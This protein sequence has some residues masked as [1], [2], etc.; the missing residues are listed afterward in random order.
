MGRKVHPIGF[1]LGIIKDWQSRWYADRNYAELVQE[2]AHP[3]YGGPAPH[4]CRA[5]S[6]RDPAL[7]QP[8]RGDACTPPS[9]V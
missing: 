6:H 9:R 3:Q 8:D 5:G 1:R 4:R 7:G 2:D